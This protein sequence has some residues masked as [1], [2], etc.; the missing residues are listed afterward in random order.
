MT[1]RTRFAPSPTGFLHIGGIRTALYCYALAKKHEG[2]FVLRIED[3]DRSR[4]VEGS[5]EEIFEMLK[6]YYIEADESVDKE[7]EFGPYIQS[8]RLDSY[9]KYAEELVQKDAAYYCFLTDEEYDQIKLSNQAD[10][11]PFRSPHRSLTAAEVAE[12]MSAGLSYV[13]RQRMPENRE[14]E[15]EDGVQGKMRFNSDEVDEG[16]LLKSDGF[17]T[18]HLAMLVDDHLMQISHVFRAAEWVSS[19]PKHVLL[20][21]AMGWDI[22]AM[23]H[24]ST[25]LDPGGGKLSKRKGTVSAKQFVID[26][27]LPE[28]MLNFLMLLGWSAPIEREYGEKEREIFSLAEFVEMFDVKDLNKSNPIF[29]RD[30]LQWF[31]Q[32]YLINIPASE[33]AKRL[34]SWLSEYAEL[35]VSYSADIEEDDSL[36]VKLKL[37]KERSKSLPEVVEAL[38]FFYKAPIDIDWKIKQLN[39]VNEVNAKEP[40]RQKV[41][42]LFDSFD[43]DTTTWTHEVWEQGMRD[44]ADSLEL[45]HG[46][47]F[48]FLRIAMVGGPF[49]PPLFECLQILGKQEVMD[50]LS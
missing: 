43:T 8:E 48:M 32:Q 2:S 36:A 42:E 1:V 18:Y 31:N 16:V 12:K 23:Y 25:I 15:F 38:E 26:G 50:R 14:I 34:V 3:T 17:P 45:K 10:G 7:G 39:R 13:I 41:Y 44:I 37:V 20:Y 33:L 24:L 6:Y 47:V 28:A 27:Y 22:P 19:I 5:I 35:D 11:T 40:L 4:Y 9:K 21:E 49:S 30:K 29:D 46:D